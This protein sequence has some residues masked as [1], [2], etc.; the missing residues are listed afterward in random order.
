LEDG[1]GVV[2]FVVAEGDVLAFREA[3][4]GE[5]E[6]EDGDVPADEVVDD[7]LAEWGWGYP[8]S[9]QLALPWR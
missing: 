2:A 3:A 4:A 6:G 9:R 1:V 5:V 7:P 8:S